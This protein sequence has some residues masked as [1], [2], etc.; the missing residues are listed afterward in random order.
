MSQLLKAML[1]P[2][3]HQFHFG[4][5]DVSAETPTTEPI[6]APEST[7]TPTDEPVIEEA[8]ATKTYTEE[9]LKAQL[10]AEA[11]KIRNKY[12]RK[13]EKARIEQETRAKVMQE[14][15]TR[16]ASDSE[17]KVEDYDNYADYIRDLTRWEIKSEREMEAQA[18]VQASKQSEQQRKDERFAEITEKG[19]EKYPDFED[20]PAQTADLLKTKGLAFKSAMVDTLIETENAA[21]IVH[22]LYTNPDEAERIAKLPAYGQ[23][24]EIGK[25]EDKLLNATPKK[26][27]SKAPAP[28]TP[29]GTGKASNDSLNDELPIEEWLARRNKQVRG[30]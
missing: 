6:V 17:P 27:I 7:D 25:L 24:K 26:P 30:R 11:A 19:N 5:G 2:F 12:E 14:V 16:D 1:F 3:M 8:V 20:M 22:Y 29:V 13:L 21:D 10:D 9:E 15:A 4:D 18:K 23:A 28:I